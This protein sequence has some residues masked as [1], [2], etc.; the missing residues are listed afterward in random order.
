MGSLLSLIP[1]CFASLQKGTQ[2]MNAV[3]VRKKGLIWAHFWSVWKNVKCQNR[4]TLFALNRQFRFSKVVPF[5]WKMKKNAFL[6]KNT[7]DALL[8]KSQICQNRCF[9]KTGLFSICKTR[10][11]HLTRA[12]ARITASN[13]QNPMIDSGYRPKRDLRRWVHTTTHRSSTSYHP[14]TYL[15]NGIASW[16]QRGGSKGVS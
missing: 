6:K 14:Y 3:F 4:Y 15:I 16:E 1:C 12:R 2:I 8:A 10:E 9:F 11:T 5:F 7:V 13:N